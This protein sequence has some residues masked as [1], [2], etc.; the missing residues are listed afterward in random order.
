MK[1]SD[2]NIVNVHNS[3]VG[4]FSFGAF[5]ALLVQKNGACNILNFV[6]MFKAHNI[7]QL[8][9]VSCL[10]SITQK[11]GRGKQGKSGGEATRQRKLPSNQFVY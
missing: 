9:L 3:V 11:W 8:V 6:D 10:Y 5:G 2:K 1:I 7:S 4:L